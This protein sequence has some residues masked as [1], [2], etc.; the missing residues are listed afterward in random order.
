MSVFS[1]EHNR[2]VNAEIVESNPFTANPA[3][4]NRF[5]KTM[6]S[7]CLFYALMGIFNF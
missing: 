4:W 6:L 7:I 3:L 2:I 5:M 1:H